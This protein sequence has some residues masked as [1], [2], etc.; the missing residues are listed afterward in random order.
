MKRV[1]ISLMIFTAQAW[2]E[3]KAPDFQ[4]MLAGR[5]L[6]EQNKTDRK[7]AS[8]EQAEV[9]YCNRGESPQRPLGTSSWDTCD[10]Y[11][12]V[13]YTGETIVELRNCFSLCNASIRLKDSERK[14]FVIDQLFKL[15]LA[16]RAAGKIAQ[17][18]VNVKSGKISQISW[19]YVNAD[20]KW[21]DF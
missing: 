9:F 16:R 19:G 4:A 20:S 17:A 21:Q 13:H 8:G 3:A 12:I 14:D 6:I 1:L 2:G 5:T 18:T 11:N 10:V 15:H 7:P